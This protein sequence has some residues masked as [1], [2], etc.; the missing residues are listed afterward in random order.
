MMWM[1]Y[2]W[3]EAY[4]AGQALTCVDNSLTVTDTDLETINNASV[5][6]SSVVSNLHFDPHIDTNAARETLCYCI[7]KL[8]KYGVGME[9][10]SGV[11]D[12]CRDV[13]TVVIDGEK[14][15]DPQKRLDIVDREHWIALRKR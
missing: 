10:A 9:T 1:M 4:A 15:E 11:L 14:Y 12:W 5:E 3:M 6:A 7:A 8:E 2:R 13:R